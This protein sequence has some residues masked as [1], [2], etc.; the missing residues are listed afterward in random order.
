[1]IAGIVVIYAAFNPS[2]LACFVCRSFIRRKGMYDIYDLVDGI[3]ASL[4]S[5]SAASPLVHPWEAI[6]IGGMGTTL[7]LLAVPL[8]DRLRL[9]DPVHCVAVHGVAGIW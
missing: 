1:M 8:I 3:L 2:M 9:D 5:I 7:T 6:L 4:V